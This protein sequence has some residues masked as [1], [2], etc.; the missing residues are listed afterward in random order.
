MARN[1]RYEK[2]QG[3]TY[4]CKLQKTRLKKGEN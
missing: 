3:F 4:P 1:K 2:K